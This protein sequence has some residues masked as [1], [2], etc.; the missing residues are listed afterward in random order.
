MTAFKLTRRGRNAHFDGLSPIAILGIE[1]MRRLDRGR[2][3]FDLENI[4][5]L[6]EQLVARYGSIE[7]AIAA[8]KCGRVGFEK[9]E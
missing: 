9:D 2:G 7:N 3:D 8:V 4:A 1:I 6:I 5:D